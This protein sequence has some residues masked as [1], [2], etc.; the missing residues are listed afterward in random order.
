MPEPLVAPWEVTGVGVLTS[1]YVVVLLQVAFLSELFAAHVTFKPLYIEVI[2]V[3][4]S[5]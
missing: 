4:M 1:V 5:L 3:N 2:R